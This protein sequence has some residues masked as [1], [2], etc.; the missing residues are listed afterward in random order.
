ME[1]KVLVTGANGFIGSH[2][3]DKLIKQGFSVKCMVRKTSNLRW[4]DKC[5]VD[6]VCAD[7]C[8]SGSLEE[9]VKDVDYI[10][11]LGGTVRMVNSHRFYEINSTGTKNLV[12]AVKKK[13]PGIKKFVYVSTLAAGDAQ[14]KE[15]V[16]H[17]GKSKREAEEWVKELEVYSIVRPTGVY[18]PR[19]TDFLR[20]FKMAIKGIFIKP[21]KSGDLSFIHVNDCV[22]GILNAGT[23]KVS[24]LSDGSR[25]SWDEVMK[26]LE[27]IL[28]KKIR[29]VVIPLTLIK[30]MGLIG[31]VFSKVTGTPV[32]LNMDKVKE[33]NAG[34]WVVTDTS[35]KAEY[36]LE[37]GLRDTYRWYREA[38]WL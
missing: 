30:V 37:S 32:L 34:D 36:H 10:Y 31:T 29:C 5:L 3:V 11:H 6:C 22:E 14:G 20:L 19:D 9:A 18:G 17:Y 15:P 27:N 24:F 1:E 23:G 4:I 16:S 13:N 26:V 38:G 35:V 7:M 21:R 12:E 25:Y 33:I 8:D 28:E 2:L